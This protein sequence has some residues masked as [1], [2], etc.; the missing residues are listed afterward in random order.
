[1][2]GR[3]EKDEFPVSGGGVQLNGVIGTVDVQDFE[4]AMVG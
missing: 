2:F 3:F 1:V 4:T